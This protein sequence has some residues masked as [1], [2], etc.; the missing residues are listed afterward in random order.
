M[1]ANETFHELLLYKMTIN[2]SVLSSLMKHRVFNNIYSCKIITFDWNG[3][4][5]GDSELM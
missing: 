3:T 4:D 5:G 1:E 2:F